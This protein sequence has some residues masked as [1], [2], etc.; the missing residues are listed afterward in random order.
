MSVTIRGQYELQQEIGSGGMGKV[1]QAKDLKLNRSVAIKRLI[2]AGNSSEDKRRR[3]IIE[4]QAASALNQ[5][6]I[7][8]LIRTPGGRWDAQ[9]PT[10]FN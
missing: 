3:F 4:A 10:L 2:A 9:R 5:P 7:N 1:Y 8:V 6:N